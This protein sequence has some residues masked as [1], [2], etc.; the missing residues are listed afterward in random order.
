MPYRVS[1]VRFQL[2]PF[3]S[4]PFSFVITN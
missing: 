1:P 2:I 4:F 3:F